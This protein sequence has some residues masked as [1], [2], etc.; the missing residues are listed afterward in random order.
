MNF[1]PK[2]FHD[3]KMRSYNQNLVVSNHPTQNTAIVPHYTTKPSFL[4][5]LP[6]H[7]CQFKVEMNTCDI[8]DGV[9]NPNPEKSR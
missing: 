9:L 8:G 7:C 2:Q 4:S 3:P 6:K 5:N 1:Y